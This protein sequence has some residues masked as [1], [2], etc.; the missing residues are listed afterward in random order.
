VP[1]KNLRARLTASVA[2]LDRTRLHDRYVGLDITPLDNAPRRVPVRVGGEVQSVQVVPRNGSPSVEIVIS[3]G[4][5]KAV[6][7]FLGRRRIAGM[8]PGR[9]VLLEGV[10]REDR[11]RLLLLNPAYT[12]LTG[13]SS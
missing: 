2:D 10:G 4:H 8:A 6:A 13:S 3:D 1:F 7:I 5:G 9:G 11:G 12:L